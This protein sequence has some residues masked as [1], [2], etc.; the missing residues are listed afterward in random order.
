MRLL[1]RTATRI[2]DRHG[3]SCPIHKQLLAGLVFL[4]KHHILFSAAS[5]GTARR[6]GC[7]G[8]HPGLPAPTLPKAT[9]ASSAHVVAADDE[10]RR[11]RH[12][13]HRW[14]AAWRP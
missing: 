13:L 3:C 6:N 2:M 9:A 14:P 11:V 7:T 4:P 5:V 12:G 1:H 8:S 10:G